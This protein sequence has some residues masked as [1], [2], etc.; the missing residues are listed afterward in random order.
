MTDLAASVP[1][2]RSVVSMVHSHPNTRLSIEILR[3]PAILKSLR[4]GLLDVGIAQIYDD[5]QIKGLSFFV[6]GQFPMTL[7]AGGVRSASHTYSL[8]DLSQDVWLDTEINDKHPSYIRN[9]F[10][11]NGLRRPI[12]LVRS[13]ANFFNIDLTMRLPA[14]NCN[15]SASAEYFSPYIN[16]GK[17]RL[18]KHDFTLPDLKLMLMHRSEEYLSPSAIEFIRKLRHAIT[19]A[20]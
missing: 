10:E 1:V 11:S 20:F 12:N 9:L 15:A 7:F 19:L 14:I 2:A 4:E 6:I 5:K 16:T 13:S 18:L 8:E 3:P 17:I